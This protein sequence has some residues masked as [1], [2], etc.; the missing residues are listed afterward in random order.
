VRSSKLKPGC[1][2]CILVLEGSEA[3]ASIPPSLDRFGISE[4]APVLVVSRRNTDMALRLILA[5][6]EGGGKESVMLACV[7][8]QSMWMEDRSLC[9]V[10]IPRD[11][12][13]LLL[14][15]LYNTHDEGC[16]KLVLPAEPVEPT[17]TEPK[18]LFSRVLDWWR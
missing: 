15:T 14:G 18:S 7:T 16:W 6:A 1:R 4:R 13:S 10:R 9:G 11:V 12:I 5:L 3:A 2:F 8:L 17:L